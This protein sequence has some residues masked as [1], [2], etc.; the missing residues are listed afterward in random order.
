MIDLQP[1]VTCLRCYSAGSYTEREVRKTILLYC[2]QNI[3]KARRLA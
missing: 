2:G 3:L 1:I